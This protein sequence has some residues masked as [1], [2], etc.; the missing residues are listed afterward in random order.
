MPLLTAKRHGEIMQQIM[1]SA[2]NPDE[3]AD[4]I[5]RLQGDFTESRDYLGRFGEVV[6]S[7]ELD[8]YDYSS[9]WDIDGLG[10]IEYEERLVALQGDLDRITQ[11]NT[12]IRK[13]YNERFFG[14]MSDNPTPGTQLT[15][16]EIEQVTDGTKQT[17]DDLFKKN[18]KED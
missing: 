16:P 7:E 3:I 10:P 14:I 6:I 11:D 15:E 18:E 12:A 9:S 5:T 1:S 8:E 4:I 17:F 13:A 2:T